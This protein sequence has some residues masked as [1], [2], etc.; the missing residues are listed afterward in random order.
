VQNKTQMAQ[1][2]ENGNFQIEDVGVALA[3]DV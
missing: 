2:K 1:Q 3:R